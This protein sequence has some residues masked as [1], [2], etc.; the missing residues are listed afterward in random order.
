MRDD[1]G[2]PAVP[3]QKQPVNGTGQEDN[4]E[5]GRTQARLQQHLADG[6]RRSSRLHRQFLN[7][8]QNTMQQMAHLIEQQ[9]GASQPQM[10]QAP[11]KKAIFD[12]QALVEFATGSVARCF[13]PEYLVYENR[14]SPRI[15]NGELLLM[16]RVVEIEGR[17]GEIK[18]PAG[19]VTEYDVPFEGAWFYQSGASTPYSVLMEMALQP[20]GL[21][22]AYLGTSLIYPQQDYYFRNLDGDAVTITDPDLRGETVTC[23]ARLLSSVNNDETIIQKFS[24][25]LS[26]HGQAFY[27]GGSTFGFFTPEAMARQVG[28]DKGK[29]ALPWINTTCGDASDAH[30]SVFP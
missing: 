24:F 21:L 29:E 26:C 23:Q 28:L 10:G 25:V 2:K 22:S 6:A 11:V 27:R 8:R 5:K 1:P 16:S 19:I 7:L 4:P 17:R 3:S 15:P 30:R 9:I 12:R 20:C 13:G 18:P 14:R